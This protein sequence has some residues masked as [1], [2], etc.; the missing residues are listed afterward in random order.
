MSAFIHT[1][2]RIH[3]YRFRTTAGAAAR[4]VFELISQR[5]APLVDA[6]LRRVCL[7]AP[8][9]SLLTVDGY[10]AREADK[11]LERCVEEVIFGQ[12]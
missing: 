9:C 3:T 8:G 4:T 10:P 1:T 2:K 11:A 7:L 5:E 12:S 6:E